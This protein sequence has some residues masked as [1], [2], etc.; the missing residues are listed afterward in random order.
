M[1]GRFFSEI[2]ND[3]ALS[4][5]QK[6]HTLLASLLRMAALEAAANGAR[7]DGYRG[8]QEL[9]V[10]A[11]DWDVVNDRVY[12]DARFARM[13]GIA[14]QD[15]SKG[16][17]IGAWIDAV[18]PDDKQPLQNEIRKA[19]A[20]G[21]FSTEYRVVTEGRTR[22]LYAR[23]KCTLDADGRAIRFPGAIVEIT[24]EKIDQVSIAPGVHT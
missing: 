22:W 14:P 1:S 21:L 16:T 9:L 4:A 12:A 11:W 10:G 6:G 5:T 8:P 7:D 20:G 18:H 3:L 19:L 15:A 24:H 13:F 2:C 23:G 17:P